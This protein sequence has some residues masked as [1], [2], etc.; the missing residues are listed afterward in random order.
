MVLR[1]GEHGWRRIFRIGADLNSGNHKFSAKSVAKPAEGTRMEIDLTDSRGFIPE[2]THSVNHTFQRNQ[3]LQT[4]NFSGISG[5]EH[6]VST[7]YASA[8]LQA[9]CCLL[10]EGFVIELFL[11]Q[12]CSLKLVVSLN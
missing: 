3:W 8:L 6:S 11:F 2:K 12:L 1:G 5:P 10:L 9:L 4:I 7:Q